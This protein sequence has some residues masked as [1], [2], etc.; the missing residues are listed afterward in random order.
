MLIGGRFR[1]ER[2]IAAG[3]MGEVWEG[4]HCELQL[5]V[6]LKTLRREMCANQ[7]ALARFSRE[8]F[9]LGRIQSEHVARVLD[10][11][12]DKKLGPVLVMEFVQGTL[13]AEFIEARQLT[14]EEAIE[15]GM[16]IARGLRE[17]HRA[18]VVH[19]DVKPSNIILRP[20]Y[21][22]LLQAVFVDLGLGRLVPVREDEGLTEITTCD[23]AVGTAEYMAPEQILNSRKVTAS[24]DLY[25]VGT[26]L[27]RAVS[28]RHVFGEVRG[29]DLL[30]CKL[31]NAA[32]A[33]ETG[34]ADRV[35]V[36]FAQ[37][38]AR[39]LAASPEDR[40][41]SAEELLAALTL[42]RDE[43]RRGRCRPAAARSTAA[44]LRGAAGALGRLSRR[45]RLLGGLAAAA[46]AGLACGLALGAQASRPPRASAAAPG[47]VQLLSGFDS[48]RCAIAARPRPS[49]GAAGRSSLTIVC[50]EPDTRAHATTNGAQPR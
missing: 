3:G 4:L 17:L 19:R 34:R 35:A 47:G 13:L 31:A 10:F 29:F 50:E 44:G 7:Q 8:A 24:A 40:F 11:V 30:K 43:A 23:H 25:A 39:A 42:L 16:D 12:A 28:G 6:A 36:G 15:L 18:H 20:T 22:G 33:L 14:I 27:Y 1:V 41:Q 5:P 37:L 45:T 26:I 9:L 32:P 38:I 46:L 49:D 48:A 2:R 21:D